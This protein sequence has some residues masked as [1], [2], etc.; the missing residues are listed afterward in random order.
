MILSIRVDDRLI[1]GQV[2]L[3]WTKEYSTNRIVVA[4]DRASQDKVMQMTL[5]M[6]TPTGIKLLIK[7]VNDSIV[8]FNDERVKP[9][10]LFV[11]T[12]TISDA[13][14]IA[15]HC[16]VESINVANVGRFEDE[17]NSDNKIS[18]T[19][20]VFVNQKELEALKQLNKLPVEVFHQVVP[21][22]NK[23]K[24]ETLLKKYL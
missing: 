2:A 18:L 21:S 15:Q 7:S 16:E 20:Q 19:S 14:E 11:L 8:L 4:N 1:H 12:N 17:D 13:L 5:Q 24:I 9:L 22:Q 10:P 6:A 23:V 3:V